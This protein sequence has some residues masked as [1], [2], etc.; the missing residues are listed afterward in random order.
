[1]FIRYVECPFR[2]V[3]FLSG[4]VYLSTI[5]TP[6]Q[7]EKPLAN[8]KEVESKMIAR[9]ADKL[10]EWGLF[11]GA[12]V[13]RS[14]KKGDV[15]SIVLTLNCDDVINP[16]SERVWMKAEPAHKQVLI[17]LPAQVLVRIGKNDSDVA[18]LEAFCAMLD[19]DHD[20]VLRHGLKSIAFDYKES[21]FSVGGNIV[22]GPVKV[23][24]AVAV[25]VP[26]IDRPAR[27][28]LQLVTTNGKPAKP[29]E[30]IAP[31]QTH[32]TARVG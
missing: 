19:A 10:R 25:S 2:E 8:T 14:L 12:V 1:M 20:G 4:S 30:R 18:R 9:V 17:T 7:G 28:H 27:P 26:K 6:T 3:R 5:S 24:L 32:R 16:H 31:R 11:E 15:G 13:Q 29:K 22:S 23:T 21:D